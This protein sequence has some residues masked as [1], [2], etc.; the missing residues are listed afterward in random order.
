MRLRDIRV[1]DEVAVGHS[2]DGYAGSCRRRAVVVN[3]GVER[4][5]SNGYRCARR[6]G[7]LIE[8]LPGKARHVVPASRVVCSWEKQEEFV[9]EYEIRVSEVEAERERRHERLR[10]F[11]GRLVRLGVLSEEAEARWRPADLT[12]DQL[13]LLLTLAEGAQVSDSAAE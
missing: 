1:G 10:E 2:G 5:D 8:Y 13:E 11:R 6:D 4:R 12:E 7:V 9:R 3:V